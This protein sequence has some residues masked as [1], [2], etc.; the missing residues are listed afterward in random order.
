MRVSPR[1]FWG[2]ANK[3]PETVALSPGNCPLKVLEAR[4][5][6][7]G[8]GKEGGNLSRRD[9]WTWPESTEEHREAR[10][11]WRPGQVCRGP[12]NRVRSLT[13]SCRE[14]PSPA[15]THARQRLPPWIPRKTGKLVWPR[16]LLGSMQIISGV[17]RGE[18]K[19]EPGDEGTPDHKLEQEGAGPG[20]SW[21][22]PC[23]HA[24]G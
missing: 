19:R 17:G 11:P 12:Q 5:W 14:G 24:A 7:L 16:P 1:G 3:G 22:H 9:V 2:L 8:A 21:P 18:E 6:V 13:S 4:V 10:A 23:M 20:H 15:S